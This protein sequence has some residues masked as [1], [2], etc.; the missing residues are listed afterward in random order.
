MNVHNIF[1]ESGAE[2]LVSRIKQLKPDAKPIWGRMTVSQMLAHC[3][4]PFETVYDSTYA[5]QYPRPNAIIRFFLRLFIKPILVNAKPYKRNMRT[6]PEFVID[7][8]RNFGEE[9]ARLIAFVEKTH[10][11]GPAKFEGKESHSFGPLTAQEWN[12][13]FCKHTDHHL[14]QFGV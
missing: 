2:A 4:K 9:Q 6:A 1:E 7:D 5:V 14:A 8:A 12:M 11:A 10:A 13:L 3:C